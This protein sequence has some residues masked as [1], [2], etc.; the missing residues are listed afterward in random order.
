[1]ILPSGG[2][3]TAARPTDNDQK[4]LMGEYVMFTV[5]TSR[6]TAT[7]AQGQQHTVRVTRRGQWRH[8]ECDTCDWRQRAQLLPRPKAERHLAEAHGAAAA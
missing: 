4:E 6:I 1:M 7:D 2:L 3:L 8:V 5:T